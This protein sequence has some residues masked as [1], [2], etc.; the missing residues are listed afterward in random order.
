[1]SERK[2]QIVVLH[3]P[4]KCPKCMDAERVA[5]EIAAELEGR[6]EVRSISTDDPEAEK[7]GVVITPTVLVNDLIVAAGVVPSKG[8]L[9]QVV[10]DELSG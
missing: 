6:V 8:R 3:P 4:K 10:A 7:Y 2:V 1:M 9:G 5:A